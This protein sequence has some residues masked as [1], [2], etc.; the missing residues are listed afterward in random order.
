[1]PPLLVSLPLEKRT[2]E[3]KKI[4]QYLRALPAKKD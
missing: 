1:M 4:Y 3:A 2:T